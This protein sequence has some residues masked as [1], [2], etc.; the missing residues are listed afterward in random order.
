MTAVYPLDLQREVHRRWFHRFVPT[1][2]FA[3]EDRRPKHPNDI[4]PLPKHPRQLEITETN[5]FEPKP[6]N[7]KLG[8]HLMEF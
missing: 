3:S 8:R 5:R 1:D 2:S 6:S 4:R 7:R